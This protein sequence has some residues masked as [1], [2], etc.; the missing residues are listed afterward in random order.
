MFVK[1]GETALLNEKVANS[2]VS[3]LNITAENTE[4]FTTIMKTKRTQNTYSS[5]ETNDLIVI[6]TVDA[7]R[8]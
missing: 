6:L 7:P 4:F 2:S 5:K 1:G 3:K 8:T